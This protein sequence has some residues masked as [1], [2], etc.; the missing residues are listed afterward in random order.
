MKCEYAESESQLKSLWPVFYIDSFLLQLMQFGLSLIWRVWG[1]AN[2]SSE[3]MSPDGKKN[4][5][6]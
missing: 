4:L 3:I 5:D 6:L 2:K 1:Q